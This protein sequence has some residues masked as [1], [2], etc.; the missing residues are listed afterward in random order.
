[1][2]QGLKTWALDLQAYIP[3]LPVQLYNPEQTT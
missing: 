2:V 3:V 1:M